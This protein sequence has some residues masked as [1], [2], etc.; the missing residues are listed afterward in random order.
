M[1]YKTEISTEA[2]ECSNQLQ[3]QL[4]W[5]SVQHGHNHEQM[6]LIIQQAIDKAKARFNSDYFDTL[7]EVIRLFKY[8]EEI[9]ERMEKKTGSTKLPICLYAFVQEELTRLKAENERLTQACEKEF[10]SVV[11]MN[12]L[13]ARL[14]A[15][16]EELQKDKER[17]DW[18]GEKTKQNCTSVF[19][20]TKSGLMPADEFSVHVSAMGYAGSHKTV[21][22]AIDAAMNQ[23]NEN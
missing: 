16:V 13:T 21:R 23:Q 10:Q 15:E 1:N 6:C 19:G 5:I 7:A 14:R 12:D 18:I 22:D 20:I 3:A 4:I 2:R 11:E 8:D 9:A 17:L